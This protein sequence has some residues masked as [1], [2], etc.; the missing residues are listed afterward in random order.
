MPGIA[1]TTFADQAARLRPNVK[2]MFMTAYAG[3]SDLPRNT[4]VLAKPFATERSAT[5]FGRHARLIAPRFC[6]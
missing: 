4:P 2:V 6:R 3:A 1:G 5:R